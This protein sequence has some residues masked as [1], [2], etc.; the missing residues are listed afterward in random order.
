MK[1]M[2]AAT[3]GPRTV[4]HEYAPNAEVLAV[5]VNEA[6]QD[7]RAA[8]GIKAVETGYVLTTRRPG[9]SSFAS[10]FALLDDTT[11]ELIE[12]LVSESVSS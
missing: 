9:N 12:E 10:L 11:P 8:T 6:H 5:L 1:I 7:G 2:F 3:R 4:Q